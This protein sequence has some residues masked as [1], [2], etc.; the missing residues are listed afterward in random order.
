MVWRL[1]LRPGFLIGISIMALGDFAAIVYV[2]VS[3]AARFGQPPDFK[4]WI[5]AIA[6]I[7][8][9]LGCVLIVA[10]LFFHDDKLI[11]WARNWFHVE[12]GE[13]KKEADKKKP[14]A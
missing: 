1:K 13:V 8:E 10:H 5:A 7:A 11:A 12:Q 9:S 2:L 6:I 14:E 4:T 3:T